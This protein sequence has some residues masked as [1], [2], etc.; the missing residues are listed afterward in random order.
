MSTTAEV[1]SAASGTAS[2]LT[3]SRKVTV[4][5]T[6]DEDF[7]RTIDTFT[8]STDAP[9]TTTVTI[10]G[11]LGSDAATRVFATSNGDD[12]VE[13]TDQW[14]GTD[15]GPG[16]PAV[17]HY[18]HGFEGLVPT[19]TEVI[20]DNVRWTY[21]LIVQPGETVRLGY[22]TIVAETEADAIAAANAL[23]TPDGFGGQAVAFLDL[24]ALVSLANF[25]F[26]GPVV[27][28]ENITIVAPAPARRRLSCRQRGDGPMGQLGRGRQ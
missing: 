7:A 3:V 18:I 19:S 2:G 15:G 25:K 22:F 28:D 14:I 6:G 5:N 4:P 24:D 26:P 1:L 8:N 13:A 21:D 9:I 12:I 27:T 23:V 16:T 10:V 17:I 20:G 11:N